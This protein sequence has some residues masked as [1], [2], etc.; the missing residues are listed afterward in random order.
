MKIG[1]QFHMG[2]DNHPALFKKTKRLSRSLH[3][4]SLPEEKN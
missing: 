4:E 2:N 3:E 1:I